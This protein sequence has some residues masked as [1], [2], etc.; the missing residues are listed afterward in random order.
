MSE[1]KREE[2]YIVVKL[3]HLA[4]L[5]VAPL[6]NFLREIMFQRSIAL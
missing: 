1:F 2:R 3:K 6:R 4:G 5:E